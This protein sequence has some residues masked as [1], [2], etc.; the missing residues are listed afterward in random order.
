MVAEMW[1]VGVMQ[2]ISCTNIKMNKVVHQETDEYYKL[3]RE[4]LDYWTSYKENKFENLM[5]TGKFN[6]KNARE[7]MATWKGK[8][9]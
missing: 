2:R 7:D 4:I 6:G 3:I 9:T 5:K 1:F 8:Q